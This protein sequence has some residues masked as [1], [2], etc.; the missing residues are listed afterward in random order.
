MLDETYTSGNVEGM[1][2]I[3]IRTIQDYVKDFRDCFSAEAAKP[4]KGRRFTD[5][6]LKTLLTIKR[7]RSQRIPDDDIRAILRGEVDFPLAQE[8]NEKDIKQIAINAAEMTERAFKVLN[9][10]EAMMER[11]EKS[12][13]KLW[14]D[15]HFLKEE[16]QTLRTRA[17]NIRAWQMF[18]MKNYDEFNPYTEKDKDPEAPQEPKPEKKRVGLAGWLNGG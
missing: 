10:C 3:P 11:V 4:A 12:Q 18:M 17:D 13:V 1:T 9:E 16:F 2:G 14:N 5:A 7:A 8:Y 6:D 15:V